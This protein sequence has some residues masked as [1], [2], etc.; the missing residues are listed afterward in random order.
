MRT[1]GRFV[2][3]CRAL[4]RGAG[5]RR[6][7]RPS[8]GGGREERGSEPGLVLGSRRGGE[9]LFTD[10]ASSHCRSVCM[11]FEARWR[12]GL[13]MHTMSM[14]PQRSGSTRSGAVGP[15]TR[16]GF[17]LTADFRDNRAS[18]A[19][20]RPLSVKKK[21]VRW[22]SGLPCPLV[23]APP[24]LCCCQGLCV[25]SQARLRT[26]I[27][28]P[29][30]CGVPNARRMKVVSLSSSSAYPGRQARLPA[31]G[32]TSDFAFASVR[33]A[34]S[35]ANV[36]LPPTNSNV[37]GSRLH[38][39]RTS[40]GCVYVCMY[41]YVCSCSDLDVGTYVAWQFKRARSGTAAARS[42]PPLP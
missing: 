9:V 3:F 25:T 15:R 16:C 29:S 1:Q 31:L 23:P 40:P 12:A 4:K 19:D 18:S 17:A 42:F 32:L 24:L 34:L 27:Y 14:I 21:T 5:G 22:R 26:A 8:S 6:G 41:V 38:C 35:C 39:S 33:A 10:L 2:D 37:K 20:S 30:Q 36:D 28:S 7:G 11:Y 13:R